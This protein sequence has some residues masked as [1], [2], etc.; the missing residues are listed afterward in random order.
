MNVYQLITRGTLEKKIMGLKWF[1]LNIAT[2][3]VNQQNL[4]LGSMNMDQILELFNVSLGNTAPPGKSGDP[5]GSNHLGL[6][7]AMGAAGSKKNMLDGLKDLPPKSK[8]ESV[9]QAKFHSSL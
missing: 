3:I 9:D 5:A 2:S 1:K 8:Y 7:P 6:T 4:N